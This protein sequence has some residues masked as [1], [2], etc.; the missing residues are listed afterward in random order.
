MGGSYQVLRPQNAY[1][2][3][4]RMLSDPDVFY[5]DERCDTFCCWQDRRQPNVDGY[6][7]YS[8]QGYAEDYGNEWQQPRSLGRQ[9]R[10]YHRL[11]SNHLQLPTGDY[12]CW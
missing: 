1:A 2:L 7:W 11:P 10:R 5:Q 3:N 9:D 6:G 12:G 4:S 8:R